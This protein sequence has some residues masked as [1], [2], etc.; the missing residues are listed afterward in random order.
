MSIDYAAE[1]MTEFADRTGLTSDRPPTRYLWTDAFA[2][3]NLLQL[4][5]L[6]NE[7]HF[8]DLARK[9]VD[10][11]HHVLGQYREDDARSGWLSGMALDEGAEHP[12]AGGL[13]IGKPL[14]ERRPD[15]PFDRTTEWDR[16]GQ[17]F[18]YLTKWM[19]ALDQMAR[20]TGES[21]YNRWARELAGAAHDG[22]AHRPSPDAQPRMYWKMSTDLT[23]SLA[24]SMGQHDPLDGY[25]TIRQLRH[26][27]SPPPSPRTRA[28]ASAFAS[29]G[30][31]SACT[32]SSRCT[33]A[34]T[35][36]RTRW[37]G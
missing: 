37:S 1:L 2:V 26:T 29:W 25:V 6:S 17:Y 15:E 19:H 8:V 23:R 30:S 32:V 27:A 22:F 4:S 20:F 24:P 9:L 28:A 35:S 31:P 33:S 13:R 14:P 12:T 21:T 18:H 36:A 34:A 16:D 10:Q 5:D 3:C 7:T 11:V